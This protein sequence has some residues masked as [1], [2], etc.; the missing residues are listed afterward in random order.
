[1][2]D[3][4]VIIF[5]IAILVLFIIN[6][7]KEDWTLSVFIFVMFFVLAILGMMIEIPYV[8]IDSA[9]AITTDYMIHS[10]YGASVIFS[11]LGVFNMYLT[12]HYWIDS[13]ESKP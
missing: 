12:W 2:I 9:D 6:F 8:V 5:T 13:K 1:M 10:D 4:L 3:S 11:L 7:Y